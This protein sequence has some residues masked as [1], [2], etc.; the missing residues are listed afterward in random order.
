[1]EICDVFEVVINSDSIEGRGRDY[2]C[3]RFFK[4]PAAKN[5]A[6]GRDVMGS[7]GKVQKGRVVAV[8][9]AS[10]EK[11]YPIGSEVPVFTSV[12]D[13]ARTE[14]MNKLTPTERKLL[15]LP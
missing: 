2:V 9:T 3:A 11:F 8:S 13:K 4:E 12:E 5:F 15:G 10:G 7:D 14:A 6:K 1:M